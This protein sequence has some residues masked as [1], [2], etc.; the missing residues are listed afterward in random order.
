MQFPN[1]TTNNFAVWFVYISCYTHI[2]IFPYDIESGNLAHWFM[3]TAGNPFFH[4][5]PWFSYQLILG[6]I[7]SNQWVGW[8]GV[9]SLGWVW[10]VDHLGETHTDIGR[11]C[12]LQTGSAGVQNWNQMAGA[13]RQ[14]HYLQCHCVAQDPGF[15]LNQNT[16]NLRY[17]A[18]ISWS[19]PNTL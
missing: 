17:T 12:K 3:S 11:G 7:Y 16:F 18:I 2:F 13:V 4:T 8:V 5:A 10:R 1:Q 19:S 14:P 6:I 15:R 9:T